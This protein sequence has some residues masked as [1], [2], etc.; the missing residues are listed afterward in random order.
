M[1]KNVL[2]ILNALFRGRPFVPRVALFFLAFCGGTHPPP[3]PPPAATAVATPS[4]ESPPIAE[5]APD[6]PSPAPAPTS[7]VRTE[8][9]P[10][11]DD[12]GEVAGP[13][14]ERVRARLNECYQSGKKKNPE[15]AGTIRIV[16][17]VNAAGKVSSIAPLG[18]SE[19]DRSVVACMVKAAKKE[20]FDGSACKAKTVTVTKIYGKK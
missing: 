11:Q 13:F 18:T 12:C 4:L 5:N 17:N 1:Q 16:V 19:L 7:F 8:A 3:A 9:A 10:S 6:L 15:L 2:L 20:P 14:E